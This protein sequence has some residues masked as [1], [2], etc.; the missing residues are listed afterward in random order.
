MVCCRHHKR[1]H[2]YYPQRL[3]N[4]G[5]GIIGPAHDET[6][7]EVSEEM[8]GEVALILKEIMIPSD[9]LISVKFR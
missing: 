2:Q 1:K 7:L 5:A 3:A 4:T 6:I 9:K 8:A